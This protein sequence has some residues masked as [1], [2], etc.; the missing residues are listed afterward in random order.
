ML[1]ILHHSC[2]QPINHTPGGNRSAQLPVR[3]LQSLHASPL[4]RICYMFF[5]PI[6]PDTRDVIDHFLHG[7]ISQAEAAEEAE[8][9][10]VEDEVSR[11]GCGGASDTSHVAVQLSFFRAQAGEPHMSCTSMQKST[12][13]AYAGSRILLI[14]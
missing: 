1:Q 2:R 7:C 9:G 12:G 5:P 3:V 10:S 4:C 11:R 6:L 8:Q 14:H 13:K